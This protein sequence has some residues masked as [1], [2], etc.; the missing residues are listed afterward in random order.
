MHI[1]DYLWQIFNF[2]LLI[3]FITIIVL[4]FQQYKK[5]KS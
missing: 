5:R 4:F 2:G 3:L 1:G